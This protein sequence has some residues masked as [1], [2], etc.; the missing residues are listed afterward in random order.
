MNKYE[1]ADTSARLFGGDSKEYEELHALI[2]SNKLVTPSI[3]G[4]FFLHHIDVGLPIAER[5]LGTHIGSLNVPTRSIFIQ[6]LLEDYGCV[7]TFEKDWS[8]SFKNNI[9]KQVKLNEWNEFKK[10]ASQ[11]VRL[12][13]CD[14]NKLRILD[15]L[16]SLKGIVSESF[17]VKKPVVYA[18]FGH[19]LGADIL[20]KLI[21]KKFL[22]Q[23]V[24]TL[25]ALIGYLNCRFKSFNHVDPVP[26][27][28]DWEKYIEDQ[29]WMH[30]PKRTDKKTTYY[31]D[32][33]QAINEYDPK[34][35]KYTI[36]SRL[37]KE[38]QGTT[39][40]LEDSIQRIIQ[41]GIGMFPRTPCNYD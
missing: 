13:S 21:N 16:F 36:A 39:R 3:F 9:P 2:D 11:D 28:L 35:E 10:R 14:E 27:L 24:Y 32:L 31:E 37:I 23:N 5:I 40:E 19:A 38:R 26:T 34:D 33:Y 41:R 15:N 7:P 18:I 4:R 30:A 12:K 29:R 25:D 20:A 6:H 1:H 17:S 22:F 8:G